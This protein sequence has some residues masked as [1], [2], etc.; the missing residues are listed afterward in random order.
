M[1]R[2][3]TTDTDYHVVLFH[4]KDDGL[5]GSA[6]VKTDSMIAAIGEA[7]HRA[8]ESAGAIAFAFSGT[9]KNQELEI[10]FRTGHVPDGIPYLVGGQRAAQ[11]I[12]AQTLR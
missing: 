12:F 3:R 8:Q 6:R 4:H 11:L 9:R 1:M 5:V 2:R 7:Q 10:L